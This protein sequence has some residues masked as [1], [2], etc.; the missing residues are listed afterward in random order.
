[1]AAVA[2]PFFYPAQ[3]IH[4][5]AWNFPS[6]LPLGAGHCGKCH[7]GAEQISPNDSEL[8]DF[9]NLGY[10]SGCARLPTERRAD[11]LRFV[12]AKDKTDRIVLNYIFERDHA[13]VEH[14][15]IEYDC[16]SRTWP[17]ALSDKCA[18][19]QAECYLAVYLERRR[20]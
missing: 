2:C 16:E 18:Q 14:G 1:M 8:R 20:R 15:R 13:P 4:S 7:A 19:R 6:R 12:I 11:C 17:T 5:I 3:K 10:A 9:C